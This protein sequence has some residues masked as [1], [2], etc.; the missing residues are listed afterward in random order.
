MRGYFGGYTSQDDSSALVLDFKGASDEDL[1][2]VRIGDVLASDRGGTTGLLE[3][4]SVGTL[5]V[6][7]R[8]IQTTLTMTRTSGPCAL[9]RTERKFPRR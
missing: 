4:S 5:P 6:G 3:R 1:G 8:R 7:T 2:S 9:R